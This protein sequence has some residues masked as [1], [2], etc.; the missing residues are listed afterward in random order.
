MDVFFL[1]GIGSVEVWLK[2]DSRERPHIL[3][4]GCVGYFDLI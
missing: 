1:L 3:M 4:L 2:T